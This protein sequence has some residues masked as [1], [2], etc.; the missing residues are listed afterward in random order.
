MDPRPRLWA[1]F[2][3]LVDAR[4]RQVVRPLEPQ[5]PD[6]PPPNLIWLVLPVDLLV[7]LL[8]LLV[9]LLIFWDWIACELIT[10]FLYSSMV[11]L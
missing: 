11:L 8:I 2:F 4:N 10:V 6:G 5:G 9:D 7:F 3:L 1:I